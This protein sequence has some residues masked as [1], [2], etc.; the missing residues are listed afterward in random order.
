MEGYKMKTIPS[1][2]Y[3]IIRDHLL[4]SIL[5]KH[6][7]DV[8]YWAGKELAR[9]FPLFSM[10]EVASFFVE[11]GWGQLVLEK[12]AKD[13]THYILTTEEENSLNI[14]QRC[15]RLEAG[16]LAEQKQ[17]QLGFLT[18]CYEEKNEKKNLVKFTLKWDLKEQI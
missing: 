11:A 10:D 14:E 8:L 6:E 9:K 15:F 2:G 4:H 1:F 17:K 18:E 3:E 12:E 7:E 13:E 16:F 5:G